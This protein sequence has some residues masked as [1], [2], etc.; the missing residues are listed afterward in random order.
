[1]DISIIICTYNRVDNLKDCFECLATQDIISPFTW[2]VLLVDNNSNDLT[3]QFTQDY[4]AQNHF[5]LRY[6]FESKQGLS[7]ARNHGVNISNGEILI[8]IDDDIRVSKNWLQSIVNTFNTQQ[9]DAVGGRIHI[10]SPAKLPKW[11]TSDMYGFLGHQDFGNE[12]RA[13]DGYKEFP[14]GG[15]MAVRRAVFE[16][17]GLF[18][19]EMGRK[20]TGLKKEELFKGEETD[21]FHRLADVGGRFYYQPEALVLHKILTYQLKPG[22][23]LTLHNNAGQLESR[24]DASTYRRAIL[25]IPLFIFP[26]FVRA[27]V[28]YI[29]LCFTKGPDFAFRQLMTVTYFLG[30]MGGYY[31]KNAN[32]L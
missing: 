24:R 15:N 32:N 29:E 7:H 20:G 30:L 8:F 25:G 18:D 22:F 14:F 19:V 31:K 17:V 23:F 9:C 4:A 3:R 5:I 10:D 28:K 16:K 11:I 1:M 2:E 13:M 26:Q 27:T 21:F 6:T 12:A